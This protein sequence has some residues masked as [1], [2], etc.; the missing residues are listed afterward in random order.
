MSSQNKTHFRA[1][2]PIKRRWTKHNLTSVRRSIISIPLM[3]PGSQKA[4][5]C[6]VA[7]ERSL[8]NGGDDL[9]LCLLACSYPPPPPPESLMTAKITLWTFPWTPHLDERAV[10]KGTDVWVRMQNEAGGDMDLLYLPSV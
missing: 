6:A 9:P 8:I 5:F 2:L 10:R 7:K 4:L 3:L 1:F